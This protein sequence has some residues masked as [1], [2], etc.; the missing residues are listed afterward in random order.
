[1]A[2]AHHDH[3]ELFREL[4]QEKIRWR[5]D[6]ACHVSPSFNCK[7]KPL[8]EPISERLWRERLARALLIIIEKPRERGA[9][10]TTR[11]ILSRAA[12]EI[13]RQPMRASRAPAIPRAH[14]RPPPRARAANRRWA[15]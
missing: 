15:R 14:D 1:M 5:R 4:H 11:R 10:A 3:V 6:V 2:S 8:Q 13:L 9:R 7:W 12:P